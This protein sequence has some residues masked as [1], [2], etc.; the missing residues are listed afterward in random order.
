MPCSH[1]RSAR[2]ITRRSPD[3]VSSIA[4]TLLSTRPVGSATSRTTCSCTSVGSF[5]AAVGHAIHTPHAGAIRGRIFASCASNTA[6]FV[7]NWITTSSGALP[8]REVWSVAAVG[9]VPRS[10]PGGPARIA[11]RWPSLI[12]SFWIRGVPEYPAMRYAYPVVRQLDM[13]ETAPAPSGPPDFDR[14]IGTLVREE[15]G[16]GARLDRPPAWVANHQA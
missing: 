7:Q 1:Q 16:L 3:Q 8:A 6:R 5:D 14:R 13:F 12:P 11:T 9:N 15:L 10:N 4:Q 2:R